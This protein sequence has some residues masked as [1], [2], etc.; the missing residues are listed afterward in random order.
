[1]IVLKV[2]LGIVQIF[3][4][5]LCVGVIIWNIVKAK[6]KPK[7]CDTCKWLATKNTHEYHV[8]VC[9]PNGSICSDW[10]HKAPE[11]CK[12]YRKRED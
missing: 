7:L 11:Y 2:V 3:G 4:L 8:Y 6:K 5:S 10:N 9:Y 12:N 1:M